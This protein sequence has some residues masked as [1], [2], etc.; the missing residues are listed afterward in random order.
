MENIHIRKHVQWQMWN[1]KDTENMH[2]GNTWKT[3]T[4]ENMYNGRCGI[5]RTQKIC[6]METHGKHS[7][8]RTCTMVDVEY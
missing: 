8:M 1:I 5:L 7:H 3:F 2:D 4:H 6:M